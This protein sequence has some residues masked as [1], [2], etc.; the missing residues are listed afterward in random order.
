MKLSTERLYSIAT[1]L[2]LYYCYLN[3]VRKVMIP[4]SSVVVPLILFFVLYIT[5]RTGRFKVLLLNNIDKTVCISW[6][7]IAFYI[8][9]NNFSLLT[10]LIDG[11]MIQLYVMISFLIFST[12][13]DEWIEKWIKWTKIY[14]LIHAVA[15]IVFYFNSDLYSKFA[16]FMFSGETLSSL[17][18]YYRLG[19]MSGLCSH[20]SSNGMI[21][22][23]GIMFYIQEVILIKSEKEKSFKS[24]KLFII[25]LLASLI[26]LYA[27]ILS[28]KR[29]PFLAAFIAI[30]TTYIIFKRKNVAKRMIILFAVIVVMII[31]FVSLA[32][33]IPGLTTIIDKTE[34]LEETDAGV[35]NG[36]LDL[37]LLSIKMFLQNPIIGLGY[38]S[39]KDYA[40]K[41]GAITTS[42]HNYYLQVM[43]ELGI[44]GLILYIIV[45]AGSIILAIKTL[46]LFTQTGE[47][48]YYKQILALSIAL[49]IQIFVII[50]S[51]TATT[52]MYYYILIP[53]FIACSV[54]RAVKFIDD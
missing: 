3:S 7:I 46:R 9:V 5:V 28:S 21:L 17:L 15:T 33:V 54:P 45:F 47:K 31:I 13:H 20:F 50:Y 4:M 39:Y 18:R 12:K 35:W 1:F 41:N 29:A 53:Y 44:I 16:N 49:E 11:G 30:C 10:N 24:Y 22:G 6:L 43:S 23:I 14:A 25:N 42:A 8:F 40:S 32:Q 26:V 2:L 52:M 51:F 34:A 38:G 37:W 36:R 19:Y 48:R 27:L